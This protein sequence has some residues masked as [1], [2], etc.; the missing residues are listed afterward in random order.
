MHLGTSFEDGDLHSVSQ[1]QCT[2]VHVLVLRMVIFIVTGAVHL[3]TCTS[4][5]DGDLH[6]VSQGQCTLVLVLRMVIFIQ[7]HRGSV[8]VLVLRMVIFIQCHGTC[9]SFED[10]DLH[11]VSQ[12][13]CTLVLVLRMVIF[14][15][16][17]RGRRKAA[18]FRW[19]FI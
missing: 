5:E 1:G 13:Q 9:T 18:V 3:G 15:Q 19:S 8:H 14:I 11:S 6:S 7:C 2:L 12:G 4:F 10:G 17:H 16:C